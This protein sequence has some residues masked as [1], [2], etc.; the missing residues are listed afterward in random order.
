MMLSSCSPF[1]ITVLTYSV[2]SLLSLPASPFEQHFGVADHRSERCA[3]LVRDGG[4][5]IRFDLVELLEPSD[6]QIEARVLL[7]QR[8]V[9]VVE[10]SGVATG[11]AHPIATGGE[12]IGDQRQ[13]KAATLR[14]A[15]SSAAR[16]GPKR[17]TP[18]ARPSN[19]SS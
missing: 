8:L 7:A 2:C 4:E 13:E 14:T 18:I 17:S 11:D 19:G 15:S 6:R 1:S 16:N 9:G 3:Q 10:R 12:Q 5:K